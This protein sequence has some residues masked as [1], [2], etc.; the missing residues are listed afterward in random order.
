MTPSRRRALVGVLTCLVAGALANCGGSDAS[1]TGPTGGPPTVSPPVGV[2]DLD[3]VGNWSGTLD[4]SFG[5]GTF[6]MRLSTSGAVG[7]EGSGSYC[8]VTGDW[9]VSEG[10]FTLRGS[11]CS[12]TIVTFK[13]PV[14]S[15][16]LAG[17]WTASSG[18]SGTFECTKQ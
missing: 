12:G 1:V 9:G 3:L 17:S 5:P 10:Q 14:S 18:R 2:V 7:T 6:T 16:R 13:A 15:T 8:P 11:D 4:G